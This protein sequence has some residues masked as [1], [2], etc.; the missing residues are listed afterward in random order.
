MIGQLLFIIN[1]IILM[2]GL[3][4]FFSKLLGHEIR[5]RSNLF[6]LTPDDQGQDELRLRCTIIVQIVNGKYI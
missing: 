1:V 4:L 6:S 5:R 3:F 2:W